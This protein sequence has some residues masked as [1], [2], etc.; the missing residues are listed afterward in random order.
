MT[1][2][3]QSALTVLD[4]AFPRP[5]KKRGTSSS[6]ATPQQLSQYSADDKDALRL[7]SEAYNAYMQRINA[8]PSD[9]NLMLLKMW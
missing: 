9:T 4:D 6:P 7:R 1:L 3:F 8:N 2:S 5:V